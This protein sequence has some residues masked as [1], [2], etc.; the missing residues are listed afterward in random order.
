M[1]CLKL[2]TLGNPNWKYHIAQVWLHLTTFMWVFSCILVNEDVYHIANG[3]HP[4]SPHIRA[5]AIR[6]EVVR[7]IVPAQN[8]TARGMLPQKFFRI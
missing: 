5:V 6:F 2:Q 3:E 7:F 4:Q 1:W 8:A